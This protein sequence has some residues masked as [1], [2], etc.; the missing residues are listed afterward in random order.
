[1]F[2]YE[3]YED[4]EIDLNNLKE[5]YLQAVNEFN[6]NSE[7]N[8]ASKVNKT[9]PEVSSDKP[10]IHQSQP[11]VNATKTD[12][13]NSSKTENDANVGKTNDKQNTNVNMES[14]VIHEQEIVQSNPEVVK[15][16]GK[17]S[18]PRRKRDSSTLFDISLDDLTEPDHSGFLAEKHSGKEW[19]CVLQDQHLC[20]FP[21]QNPQE[22]AY[23]VLLV[24]CC[25]ISL[26]DVYN[27][28]PV[29]RLTQVGSTPWVF[30]A[31]IERNLR[32]WIRALYRAC[33]RDDADWSMR[34]SKKSRGRKDKK[35]KRN[36]KV[37]TSTIDE[38]EE[39]EETL[40]EVEEKKVVIVEEKKILENGIKQKKMEYKK[41][42]N[43]VEENGKDVLQTCEIVEA[44]DCGNE[45]NVD[46]E[47]DTKGEIK[48]E[49]MRIER[50][51]TMTIEEW[52][53]G[54]DEINKNENK[55]N[56]AHE[57][58]PHME[59]KCLTAR[60]E[61][62]ESINREDQPTTSNDSEVK[63]QTDDT[64]SEAKGN[65]SEEKYE[66]K[67]QEHEGDNNDN[68]EVKLVSN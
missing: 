35:Q 61:H 5:T 58:N 24:P 26:D 21:S 44:A 13:I 2:Q 19:W 14:E 62:Q 9:K 23:D 41:D 16:E 54:E 6:T 15:R 40:E 55:E 49:K 65:G 22:L 28:S 48:R 1:M 11:D 3:N 42:E 37:L 39:V 66:I 17:G 8:G 63:Q 47:R 64:R 4:D 46:E 45:L 18:K 27:E 7:I 20:M 29:F 52:K 34:S 59:E 12:A 38:S 60:K 57:N 10:E 32:A 36:M 67:T 50:E 68:S 30:S 25:E 51:N 53:R 31:G 33:G 43:M 56:N